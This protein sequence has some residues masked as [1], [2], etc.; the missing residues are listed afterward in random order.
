MGSPMNM[1]MMLMI[2]LEISME[3]VVM[4]TTEEGLEHGC[5]D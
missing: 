1:L 4:N 3:V 2:F 5:R